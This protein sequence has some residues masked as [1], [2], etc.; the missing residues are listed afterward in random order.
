MPFLVWASFIRQGTSVV[1]VS[2]SLIIISVI[3]TLTTIADIILTEK[4]NVVCEES[5]LKVIEEVCVSQGAIVTSNS[6]INT[7]IIN[8]SHALPTITLDNGI[9]IPKRCITKI[10]KSPRLLELKAKNNRI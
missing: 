6:P 1:A 4:G 5:Q 3:K 2:A 10:M 9:T 8:E 7:S